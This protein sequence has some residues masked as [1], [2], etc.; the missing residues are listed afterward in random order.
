M[1][2]A[3][4]LSP[5]LSRRQELRKPAAR[6]AGGIVASQNRLASEIGARVLAEGGHAIDAAVATSMAVGVLEPWMSGLGATGAMLIYSAKDDRVTVVDFGARSPAALDPA[7]YPIVEGDD[8]DLFGW[9]RVKDDRNLVGAKA[10]VAPTVLAGLTTAHKAFGRRPWR[11][12]VTPAVALAR[13]G[14]VV[15]WHTTLMISGA[16]QNLLA[17]E[18]ARRVFAPAGV[19]PFPP[20]AVAE[21]PAIR[22]PN[23]ELAR[24]LATI[25]EEGADAFYR[26]PIGAALVK[27][28]RALGGV[29]DAGDLAAVTAP[30]VESKTLTHRGRKVHVLPAHSGGPTIAAAFAGL[31]A[32][33]SMPANG[34]PLDAGAFMAVAQSLDEAWRT[35]FATMGDSTTIAPRGSTTHFSVVDRDGNMVALTQTLLSLFGARTLSPSTGI[36]MN[37]GVNWFDPRPNTPNGI[38]PGKR[39]LSNYCPAIMLGDGDAVA[40]GGCGGRKILPAVFQLLVMMA[41]DLSLDDAM[42]APRIDVSGGPFVIV[43]RD[44]PED[45]RNAL[46]QSFRTR[47]V[48]RTA[49]PNH[50][51]IASVVRRIGATNEGAVEPYMPWGE[52]VAEDEV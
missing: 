15:D 9:P 26:G 31:D 10:V 45:V 6:S 48:E 4:G 40:I 37:N 28:I 41:N 38:A 50:F 25:A 2:K 30:M 16:L 29:L 1:T 5:N 34:R 8:G 32:R 51:T 17:D 11:D 12:L 20:P 24:T 22:L 19:P 46:A 21:N 13:D 23:P 42:H 33:W 44:L 39:T 7:D 43:D 52:A 36:L 3:A 49:Y 47:E 18:G 14:M 35:R 27:D